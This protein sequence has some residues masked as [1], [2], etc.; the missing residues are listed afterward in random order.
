[1]QRLLQVILFLL[2]PGPATTAF[3][4]NSVLS[5]GQWY[6]L[7]V[8]EEGVYRLD[9]QFLTQMGIDPSSVDPRKIQIY[10][11][12]GGILPQANNA[13]RPVDLIENPVLVVGEADG[14]F[15]PEDYIVFY[16]QGPDSYH[17]DENGELHY[18][19]NIYSDENFYFFTIGKENGIRVADLQDEGHGFPKVSRYNA[20]SHYE[21]EAYNILSSGREWYSEKLDSSP[22]QTYNFSFP[23]IIPDMD[24]KVTSS[25]MAQSFAPS[26]FIVKLNGSNLGEHEVEAIP[27]FRE[28]LYRYSVKGRDD[29][30]TFTAGDNVTENLSVEVTYEKNNSGRSVG[31]VNSL[32]VEAECTLHLREG[33]IIFRSLSSL[34]HPASTF[35]LTVPANDVMIWDITSPTAPAS[36]T[37]SLS[38][39]VAL[40]GAATDTLRQFIAFNP[41]QLQAP[42]FKDVVEN[43]NLRGMSTPELLIITHPDLQSEAQRLADFR[44]SNDHLDAT[45]VT[46]QKIYNEFS[47]GRPDVT[48]LR[49]F[50]R[51]LY[52]KSSRLKYLLLLGK[53]SYDYKNILKGNANLVP[54]YESR[55]SLHPLDTYGSDDYYGFLEDD[56]GEW[57]EKQGGNHTLDIG[58]GRI[59]VTNAADAKAVVDKLIRYSIHENGYGAWR[60]KVLFVA[61]D[62]DNNIHVKQSDDLSVL[63]DTAFSNFNYSKLYL[64]AYPQE[65]SPSGETSPRASDALNKAVDNGTLVVNF[66]GHGGES[67]WMQ[68][69]ILDIFMINRWNNRD[70]LPLFVTAT[71][72]FGRHDNPAVVS[73]GEIVV[74]NPKGG[75]IAIISTCRPVYSSSNFELTK[76]FYREVFRKQDGEHLRLGDIIRTTKNNSIDKAVDVNQVGN[77]NFALLGDPSLRLAYPEKQIILKAVND[78]PPGADT[79]T[80]LSTVSV[81]GEIRNADGSTDTGFNGEVEVV[82]YDKQTTLTTLG[83]ENAKYSYKSRENAVFRGTASVA[84]G[85][86]DLSFIVPKN[87]SYNP[88]A[89]KISFYAIDE[90]QQADATGATTDIIFGGSSKGGVSDSSGPDITLHIGD[91]V[92]NSGV[93]GANTL[94]IAKISD[95]SGINISGYGVGN[96]ITATLDGEETFILNEYYTASKDTYKRG[97]LLFPLN[98]LSKGKH[99]LT[100]KAWDTHNNSGEAVIEF[101]VA[102]PAGLSIINFVSYPN[103][104]FD[105][106]TLAFEHN[107][108]G[109]DLQVNLQV[110]SRHGEA[111]QSLDFEVID[112]S[113]RVELYSWDGTNS[114]GK[115]LNR[116]IYIFKISVRS[117]TDGAKNQKYQ[118]VI[119]IN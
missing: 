60:N 76:A 65:S 22:V 3:S 55:N 75:G 113:S 43:Q 37:F 108:A 30:R 62:G 52:E 12:G 106:T 110:I 96:N 88:G 104:F 85:Q 59:P 97:L 40:F 54:I 115:K 46:V 100:V 72:E 38:G 116:G 77:R 63:V 29:T 58:I 84:D 27:D 5:E 95:E 57:E 71:C 109:E 81:S 2:L 50:V 1:M 105:N 20:F 14:K 89:G 18:E 35:Q 61:D 26:K 118:K 98:D 45:V 51:H 90:Q 39:N 31:Y 47:S 42:V 70:R 119:F 102:D 92:D 91:T 94:L 4:Q 73:G 19:R 8:A 28:G 32:T 79:L 9:H 16:A 114:F 10:G 68:E 6:R 33:F 86:F 66:T 23:G 78:N 80:A 99:T 11:N 41:S 101:V 69:D 74:T 36:Q 82:V 53:G 15:D 49:D 112:S 24:V 17:Y 67:G 93:T 103:P 111:V 48:A 21:K 107:R 87:I 34:Q 44:A 83:N 56:E 25:V 117:M 7:S 13:P 64:D